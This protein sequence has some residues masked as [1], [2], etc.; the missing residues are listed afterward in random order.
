LSIAVANVKTIGLV[1]MKAGCRW[2]AFKLTKRYAILNVAADA[3][4]VGWRRADLR[5]DFSVNRSLKPR[6]DDAARNYHVKS[7]DSV[8]PAFG[9]KKA[10][11][12]RAPSNR[13][14]NCS[15]NP[16]CGRAVSKHQ[17]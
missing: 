7:F 1:I 15:F 14:E 16:L 6:M 5:P 10:S 11:I 12:K 3:Q 4:H 9:N 17:S 13:H 2:I 8:P